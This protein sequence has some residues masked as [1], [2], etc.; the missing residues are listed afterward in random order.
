MDDGDSQGSEFVADHL[1]GDWYEATRRGAVRLVNVRSVSPGAGESA[2]AEEVMRLLYEDDLDGAYTASGLDPIPNDPHGRR[3]AYAFL[4][5]RS[6]RAVVLMGH[7]DTVDTADYGSL[8]P[9]ALAPLALDARRD[10]LCR[11]VP[12]LAADLAAHPHDWMFGRGVADMKSGVAA[13]IA[14]LRRYARHAQTQGAPPLSIVLLATVDEENESAGVLQALHLL[15]RLRAEHGLEYA[16]AIN[17]DYTT[18]RYPG[19]PHRYIYSGTVG[20]LLPCFLAVGQPSHAGDPFDGLDANLIAAELVR[21][22][23]MNP[24]LCDTAGGFTTAP[25]VTLHARD[26]KTR[27]DTQLPFAAAVYLNVLTLTTSPSALLDRLHGLAEASLRRV[28][29]RVDGAEQAWLN[30][31]GRGVN[32][33]RPAAEARARSGQVLTYAALYETAV[34]RVGA[35][36]VR[37]AL[38]AAWAGLPDDLDRRECSLRLVWRLWTLSGLSAPAVIL[39]YA[40][41]YYPH[42]AATPSALHRAVSAVADA[43]PELQLVHDEYFPL[44]C[45]MSYLRLDPRVDP[46]PLR[47][48]MPVWQE[49]DTPDSSAR[50]GGY[51]LPLDLMRALDLPVANIGPYGFGAHQAGER[52]LM[53]YAFDTVPRLINETID[54]LAV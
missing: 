5:G 1:D 4:R 12:G 50:P 10:E 2:V 44:L 23:S 39:Y 24:N 8:E 25:P 13:A 19:D 52:V 51:S 48:N 40:P 45:D 15:E 37:A 46:D 43:H 16:G 18:A 14:V 26:L 42:V 17:T 22:L 53:S 54:R 11:V 3:N 29:Q 30:A 20:K 31:Q 6:A 38:D 36:G 7:I 27:Y 34:R 49:P 41:P 35:D 33:G 47:H 32:D 28:L 9:W 21:D